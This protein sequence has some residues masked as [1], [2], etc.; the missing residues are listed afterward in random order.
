MVSVRLRE[1]TSRILSRLRAVPVTL[2]Y[3]TALFTI[4][5]VLSALGPHVRDRVVDVLS[6]NLHNL[7]RG[8]VGTLIGSAFVTGEGQTYLLLPGL[9]CLLALAELLWCSRRVLQAFILGHVGATLV[10]AGGLAAAI[11]FGWLP[12]SL[13][14]VSDVGLSYGAMAVLG[15]LTAAIPVKWRAAWVA[16]WLTVAVVVIAS[17]AEFVAT[18]HAIA[19]LLG[20]LLA[21]RI[22]MSARWTKPR[23][24]LLVPTVAFGLLL[25]VGVAPASAPIA[26]TSGVTVALATWWMTRGTDGRA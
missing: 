6:T 19:L 15:T 1:V 24:A 14:G 18:G 23:L 17:G 22:Q 5:T 2:V 21:S 20:T 25:L 7:A 13:A 3:A 10:V 8:H 26:T 12:R 9:V 11:E 16:G 4:A